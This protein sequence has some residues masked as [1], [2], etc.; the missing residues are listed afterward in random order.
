MSP[1]AEGRLEECPSDETIALFLAGGL[2]GAAMTALRAHMDG[3]DVCRVLIVEA[4]R[5]S[6]AAV[7]DTRIGTPRARHLVGRLAVGDTI[8]EKYRID[9]ML[10]AGGMGTVLRGTHLA[11]DRPVA[12]K[13]MHAELLSGTDAA[14]RFAREARAAAA[15]ESHHAVRIV[16]IDRLPSGVPYMVMEYLEGRD[17]HRVL[18]QEGPLACGRVIDYMVQA[19]DAI[20]EAHGRGIIH[21]DLKPHNLFLTDDELVKV[22]DFGLAKT[23][24]DSGVRGGSGDT[25]GGNM[26]G[27]PHYMAPEQ[28]RAS[29]TVD[30][31]TDIYGLGAT[32][33]QLVAGMPP[34]VALNLYVLCA[35]ILSDAPPPLH[36]IPKQLAAVIMRCLAKDPASRY[37]SVLELA[38]ALDDAR[39]TVD[40]VRTPITTEPEKDFAEAT[41]Q[42]NDPPKRAPATVT[43][44]NVAANA[45]PFTTQ[46]EQ[47]LVTL[48]ARN[49][50]LPSAAVLTR[51]MPAPTTDPAPPPT[52]V[53]PVVEP[54]APKTERY[55]R[56]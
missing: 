21:R 38:E 54:A 30:A 48:K 32:M 10:G 27:T 15:I 41:T 49:V 25:K 14:R 26:I 36:R 19:A 6:T 31:R 47:D 51:E 43:T 56:K 35:R 29:R 39:T 37:S 2:D 20:S 50:P 7:P 23:L 13:I 46:R 44:F 24:P 52:P 9:A 16:D 8:G 11:L 34:F 5:S 12:I 17:L 40:D 4:G 42:R 3:C 1:P 45:D 28:I 53:V 55:P 22:L 33:Y 18:T